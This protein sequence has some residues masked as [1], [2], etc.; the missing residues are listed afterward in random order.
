MM[1]LHRVV[2]ALLCAVMAGGCAGPHASTIKPP[3]HLS[4]LEARL[5]KDPMDR[6][7][8]LQLGDESSVTGDHLRAEQYYE[9]A[10]ALGV[11]ADVIVPR[12]I[13]SLVA[14]KRYDEALERC[15]KRLTAKPEDR[16]TRYLEAALYSALDRPHDAERELTALVN[17][18]P[19]DPEAYLA[20]AKLYHD[21]NDARAHGMFEK[22]LELAPDGREAA[23]VRFQLDEDATPAAAAPVAVPAPAPAPVLVPIPVPDGAKP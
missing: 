16:A 7:A 11:P 19:K 18:Q 14:A 23:A 2:G 17:T 3:E 12:I 22:Y 21:T 4:P 6:Q 15:Q 8:N 9:R 1:R 10:E 20:L 5:A 13:R